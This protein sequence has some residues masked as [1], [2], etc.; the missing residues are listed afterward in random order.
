MG[1]GKSTIGKRLAAQLGR[2]FVD[3]DEAVE[4]AA[5]RTIAELFADGEPAFRALEADT[6]A[7][8][9]ERP[10]P[11]VIAA[12]GGAVVTETTRARLRDPAITV[13]WLDGSPAF[14]ASRAK[15]KPHRPLLAHGDARETLTR[16]HQE[17]AH[18][19]EE[20]ADLV[21]DVEPFHRDDDS[22]K[23]ALA[24]EVARLVAEREQAIAGA[25]P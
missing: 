3:A 18:L 25:A 2:P 12:G 20:V 16:L 8:L 11:Q 24:S 14:L 17:R 4:A 21:I 1:S 15:P 5:G 19:Y 22:P 9:L 6:L 10:D 7:A 13:V 23:Q